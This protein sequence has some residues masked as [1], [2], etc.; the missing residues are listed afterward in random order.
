MDDGRVSWSVPD[1]ASNTDVETPAHRGDLTTR[2]LV[3]S[4]ARLAGGVIVS[5]QAAPADPLHGPL[6]MAAMA[7]A[8]AVGGAVAIRAN[9]PEDI[10]A[11][12]A[13]VDLPIIGI[14][15]IELPGLGIRIT[16]TIEHARAVAAAGASIIAVDATDRAR[17]DGTTV[18]E[19]IARVRVET[20]LPVMADI[21]TVREA[22][23]AQE[24]G[25]ELIATTL[26]GYTG[27]EGTLDG[28]DFELVTQ[29]VACLRVPLVAEGRVSTPDE[30]AQAI[31]LG[32]YAVVIGEAVTRPERITA[33][34][35]AALGNR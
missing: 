32:A 13:A 1:P 30:A 28:P 35:V 20:G 29:L 19:F 17:S 34:F 2:A 3:D 33:R 12:R 23:G 11:I 9:G 10:A 21:S 22:L 16:P 8:A 6:F 27:N 24:A 4:I 15:K 14:W 31:A 18:A 7:R 25:A 5:C 26:A